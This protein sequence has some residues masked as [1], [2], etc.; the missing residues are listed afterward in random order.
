MA[1]NNVLQYVG[2]RYV[3][4]FYQ[5][6]NGTWDWL[7]GVQYE[8]LTIV[9]YGTSTY[10]SK[11]LVPATVGA[12]N[13]APEYWALTGDYNGAIVELQED[14]NQN[15]S[16]IAANIVDI[17]ALKTQMNTVNNFFSR[18][19]LSNREILIIGDSWT[20]GNSW[21]VSMQNMLS[22]RN[23]GNITISAA[24]GHGFA[25]GDFLDLLNAAPSKKYTHIIVAGYATDQSQN[26]LNVRAGAQNFYAR[27]KALY[28]DADICYLM[29]SHKK[30]TVEDIDNLEYIMTLDGYKT[31]RADRILGDGS[32]YQEDNVHPTADGQNRIYRYLVNWFLGGRVLKWC[33]ILSST[34]FNTI[35]TEDFIIM[36]PTSSLASVIN[37]TFISNLAQIASPNGFNY[38]LAA[39]QGWLVQI[40]SDYKPTIL[41][42]N[43]NNDKFNIG[44]SAGSA[45][46]VTS[47]F[48]VMDK[49]L[50]RSKFGY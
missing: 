34:Y 27:A 18:Y 39:N 42:S 11:Q 45:V 32:L 13:T 30:Y 33:G 2:A 25:A 26:I 28:P 3:P 40:N 10:T 44:V 49:I 48:S 4:V 38:I 35:L 23:A 43:N 31:V 17:N 29:L 7:S 12:P 21:A 24:G 50:P 46:E 6:P 41:F 14:V 37:N 36:R 15:T 22:L 20:A 8:P 1:G 16:D 9:K 5:N 47:V 19:N